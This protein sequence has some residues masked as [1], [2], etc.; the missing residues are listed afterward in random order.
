VL[1]S[2]AQNITLRSMN[3]QNT[4]ASAVR[5]IVVNNFTAQS[6]AFFNI[7]VGLDF[8]ENVTG[9]ANLTGVVSVTNSSFDTATSNFVSLLN[10]SGTISSFTFDNNTFA[11][12]PSNATDFLVWDSA[13]ITSMSIKSNTFTNVG[14]TL[15]QNAIQVYLGRISLATSTPFVRVDLD[16]N[17]ITG[18]NGTGIR[19]RVQDSNGTLQTKVTN[20]SV[21]GMTSSGFTQ[22]IRIEAGTSTGDSTVCAQ[23]SGNTSVFS[24]GGLTGVSNGGIGLRRQTG[25][26]GTNDTFGI[27]GLAAGTSTCPVSGAGTCAATPAVENFIN[28]QNPSGNGGYLISSTAGFSSCTLP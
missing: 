20:N 19:L 14:N 10:F 6:L 25:S 5:G 1:L 23:I 9:N 7:G 24:N 4:A 27:V 13:A 3:L 12:S 26:G 11:N 2:S 21:T 8:N 16:S 15:S 28:A 22:G 17:V 18:T